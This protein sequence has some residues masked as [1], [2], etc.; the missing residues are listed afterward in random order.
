MEKGEGGFYRLC[1]DFVRFQNMYTTSLQ[2]SSAIGSLLTGQI[3]LIHELRHADNVLSFQ[4]P[5]LAY[6]LFSQGYETGFF[7]MGDPIASYQG[8]G[9]ALKPLTTNL[10]IKKNPP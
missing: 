4:S 6:S 10:F 5:H 9:R 2:S 1:N 8:L 7:H 3:P